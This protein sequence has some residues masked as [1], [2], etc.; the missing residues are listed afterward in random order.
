MIRCTKSPR[1]DL[2]RRLEETQAQAREDAEILA[3]R[4]EIIS[5]GFKVVAAKL[6]PDRGGSHEQM[7]R[8]VKARDQLQKLSARDARGPSHFV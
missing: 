3:L 1:L 2:A 7:A 8:L 4:N 5:A 6:H